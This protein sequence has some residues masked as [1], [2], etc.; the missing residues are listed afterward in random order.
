[1]TT[2]EVS[3]TP[4]HVS[5]DDDAL[6]TVNNNVFRFTDGQWSGNNN[7]GGNFR[8]NGNSRFD[9]RDDRNSNDRDFN[10]RRS[11]DRDNGPRGGFRN[12]RNDRNDRSDFI[13]PWD[14]NQGNGGNLNGSNVGA[15]GNNLG[16]NLAN[17]ALNGNLGSSGFGFGLGGSGN[18]QLGNFGSLAGNLASLANGGGGNFNSSNLGSS[19]FGGSGGGFGSNLGTTECLFLSFENA[20]KQ[21]STLF[22]QATMVEA[23]VWAMAVLVITLWETPV[24]TMEATTMARMMM[25][26]RPHK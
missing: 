20:L 19:G 8:D 21:L 14:S 22:S 3:I 24:A 4:C 13:N 16:G 7:R 5:N 10:N 1:M 9:R 11:N 18:N 12:D 2:T 23:T 26:K 6:R 17:Q 25:A 15:W